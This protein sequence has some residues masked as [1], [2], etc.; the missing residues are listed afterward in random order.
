MEKAALR[1]LVG[2]CV[3]EVLTEGIFD[4]MMRN[5][6]QVTIPNALRDKLIA[7]GNVL[8]GGYQ[9]SIS[10]D[11]KVTAAVYYYMSGEKKNL[12]DTATTFHSK[13]I[14]E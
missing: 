6:G 1:K 2:T 14:Q 11:V 5:A 9:N 7:M 8:A 10:D 3:K 13:G 4:D 12:F